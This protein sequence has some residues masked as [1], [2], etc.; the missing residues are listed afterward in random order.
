[1][2]LV[3]TAAAIDAAAIAALM[4]HL[5]YPCSGDDAAAR[6]GYWLTDPM[7]PLEVPGRV[8]FQAPVAVA[9]G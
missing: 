6:L 1:M 8:R 7:S 4:T 5:G 3:R 2:V 9:S